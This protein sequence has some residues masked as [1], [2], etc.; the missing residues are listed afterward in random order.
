MSRILITGASR[1]I[2]KGLAEELTERGHEV[3]ATARDVTA[4]TGVPAVLRLAL[5]VTVPESVGAAVAAA[6]R[7]D[8]LISNAGDTLRAPVE[9]VP[10]AEVQRI[11]ELNTFGALRVAQAVLPGMRE[12]G[13]GRILFVSSIQGRLVIPLIGTYAAS[14]WALEAFAETLAIEARHF[15]VAVQ[16]FQ[17][18]AV[19]SGGAERA[20]MYLDDDNPYRPLLDQLPRFRSA[21]I[22]VAEVARAVAAA[23]EDERTPLRIPVGDAAVAQ[24]AARKA[25]PE[26]EPFTPAALDW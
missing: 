13:A 11:F 15:G 1:G 4:L 19:A 8:V 21:P 3:I 17:P 14:K 24:L 25:A 2:G 16:V 26:D 9:T 5:D 7:V 6:G 12:R 22:T 10:M 20:R 23:L 18:G